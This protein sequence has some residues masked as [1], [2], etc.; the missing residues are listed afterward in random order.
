MCLCQYICIYIFI[1]MYIYLHILCMFINTYIYLY[2]F[3]HTYVHR[4]MLGKDQRQLL[5]P[6]VC[7][8]IFT[9]FCFLS[10]AQCIIT[11]I[12]IVMQDKIWTWESIRQ[13]HLKIRYKWMKWGHHL[14]SQVSLKDY[15]ICSEITSEATLE[16]Y[17]WL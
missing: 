17:P 10:F 15:G 16:Q 4:N 5:V 3:T 13:E 11:G 12:R 9:F 1:Y 14:K 6:G 7:L 8:C 2:I